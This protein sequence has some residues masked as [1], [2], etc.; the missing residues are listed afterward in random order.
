M[1]VERPLPALPPGRHES[2]AALK[3]LLAGMARRGG[4]SVTLARLLRIVGKPAWDVEARSLTLRVAQAHDLELAAE[5]VAAEDGAMRL[6][7]PL[8]FRLT[9]KEARQREQNAS[10]ADT[11]ALAQV[12]TRDALLTALKHL[13]ERL[14]SGDDAAQAYGFT[15]PAQGKHF[16]LAQLDRVITGRSERVVAMLHDAT[17]IPMLS[18]SEAGLGKASA[19]ISSTIRQLERE[20]KTRVEETGRR[21]LFVGYPFLIGVVGGFFCACASGAASLFHC[22]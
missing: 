18:G 21:D 8:L 6:D 17:T 2:E 9:E 7:Q 5:P 1:E 16:D 10:E 13:R 3:G 14:I 20:F 19:E 15:A 12:K 22:Q 4:G 11:N